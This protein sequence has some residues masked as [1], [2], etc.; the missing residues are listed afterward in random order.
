[1]AS[2]AVIHCGLTQLEQH[3]ASRLALGAAAMSS[4]SS[5]AKPKISSPERKEAAST[6]PEELSPEERAEIA[7]TIAAQEKRGRPPSI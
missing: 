1:M 7:L 2:C 3:Q 4:K 6:Q 5:P